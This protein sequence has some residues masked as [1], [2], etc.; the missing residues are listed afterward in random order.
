MKN[1]VWGIS[2][3]KRSLLFKIYRGVEDLLLYTDQVL[4]ELYL[5]SS[6]HQKKT[7]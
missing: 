2:S 1:T 3:I 7:F 4:Y 6:H 5:C